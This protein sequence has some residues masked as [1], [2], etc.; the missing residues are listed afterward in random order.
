M[1]NKTKCSAHLKYQTE[2]IS[3]LQTGSPVPC[4]EQTYG[5]QGGK[6]GGVVVVVG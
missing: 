1:Q 3:A 2:S 4:R 5:H 6:A